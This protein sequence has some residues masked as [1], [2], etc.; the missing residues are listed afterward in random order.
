[1]ST[2]N[3]EYREKAVELFCLECEEVTEWHIDIIRY[4]EEIKPAL[5]PRLNNIFRRHV[6]TE[7][8]DIVEFMLGMAAVF[9]ARFEKMERDVLERLGNLERKVEELEKK[10]EKLEESSA[11][12][13][14]GSTR[15]VE[16][17]GVPD[18]HKKSRHSG[19]KET[20]VGE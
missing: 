11:G 18:R 15:I 14:R 4:V 13:M 17:E 12:T 19:E 8:A 2:E 6:R 3:E 20:V 10:V 1:M 5:Y 16:N 9:Y 7:T